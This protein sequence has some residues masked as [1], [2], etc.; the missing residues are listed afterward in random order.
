MQT[1]D[2]W[3]D[4]V[5]AETRSANNLG[6]VVLL[7]PAGLYAGIAIVNA[8]LI[9]ASQRRRQNRLVA[10][11]GATPD[12]VRRA[13]IWQAGLTSGAGLLLGAATTVMIG[14]MTRLAIVRDLADAPGRVDVPM[15]VP[16]L[17]A[18]RHR[19]DL[20]AARLP[21]RPR[22]RPHPQPETTTTATCP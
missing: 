20:R 19:S 5:T 7:G 18:R 16:W 3:I 12:Q 1:A 22:R 8:T 4:S 9:G 13:A 15:T 21:R 10:L 6:L 2:E 17:P 11:L 14:A